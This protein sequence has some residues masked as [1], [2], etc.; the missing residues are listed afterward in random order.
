[1][2]PSLD[3]MSGYVDKTNNYEYEAGEREFI[4]Q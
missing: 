3:G 4:M 1:M 2:I